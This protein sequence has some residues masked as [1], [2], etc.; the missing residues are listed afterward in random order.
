MPVCDNTEMLSGRTI[1]DR[2]G[3]RITDVACR[4]A[5]RRG[6][7]DGPAQGHAVVFVRR[8]CFVRSADGVEAMFDPTLAFCINPGE[9]ERYDHPHDDGDNCTAVALSP[10]LVASLQGGDAV[11][12]RGPFPTA[13]GSDLAHRRLL[14]SGQ[15]GNDPHVVVE[16][17]IALVA[18]VLA[19]TEPARVASGRPATRAAQRALVDGVRELLTADVDRP[20]PDLARDLGA[21]PHHMS[22]IFRAA[23]GV[24]I[25][26][27]R[28]RLRVRA[29][30]ERL[31]GG[32]RD[33]AR[34]AA[35]LGFADQSHLCRVVKSEALPAPSALRR[36][37][38]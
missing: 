3:I 34:I 30:L 25:A 22:R 21:S 37:L 17:A 8:G 36:A 23:T 33:L 31:S 11:L 1:L 6:E 29:A 15:G 38:A 26:R 16:R 20:L 27:H 19:R 7:D 14:A 32:E 18:D 2:D 28:M 35:D 4:H 10:N 5:H 9:E 12:P 13:P 24:T